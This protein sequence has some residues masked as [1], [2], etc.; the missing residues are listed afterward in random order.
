MRG[1][2]QT[3]NHTVVDGATAKFGKVVADDEGKEDHLGQVDATAAQD[4][5]LR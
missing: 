5:T 4:E 1:W 3:F 2:S